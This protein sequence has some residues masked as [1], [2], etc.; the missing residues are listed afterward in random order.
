MR[1][2]MG[3]VWQW[4]RRGLANGMAIVRFCGMGI[5]SLLER[6][7]R[8]YLPEFRAN[9]TP[10]VWTAFV[11]IFQLEISGGIQFDFSWIIYTLDTLC[12]EISC[13]NHQPRESQLHLG[14]WLKL[15]ISRQ[16]F[17]WNFLRVTATERFDWISGIFFDFCLVLRTFI[18]FAIRFYLSA[19]KRCQRIP[20]MYMCV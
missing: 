17:S 6:F 5:L 9:L 4:L 7:G 3:K 1:N 12:F 2:N 10:G 18:A 16:Q 19:A 14:W 11:H 8:I 20:L 13:F 15:E